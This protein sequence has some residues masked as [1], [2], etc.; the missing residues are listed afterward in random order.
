MLVLPKRMPNTRFHFPSFPS[1]LLH[2]LRVF[3]RFLPLSSLLA[4]AIVLFCFLLD[5]G[6]DG[7]LL[8]GVA[9]LVGV[10]DCSFEIPERVGWVGC[11]TIGILH[12]KVRAV[13]LIIGYQFRDWHR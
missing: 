6:F 3:R 9:V 12:I 8:L 11:T 2:I 1:T 13:N 4:I 5:S 10:V 7:L